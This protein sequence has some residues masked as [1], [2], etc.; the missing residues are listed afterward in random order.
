MK[1]TKANFWSMVYDHDVRVIVVMDPVR[2]ESSGKGGGSKNESKHFDRFWP[3]TM[4][5]ANMNGKKD[6]KKDDKLKLSKDETGERMFSVELDSHSKFSENIDCWTLRLKKL[7]LLN[8]RCV[9]A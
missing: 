7:S 5:T 3:T 8:L 1:S 9:R 4:A 2:N 6:H